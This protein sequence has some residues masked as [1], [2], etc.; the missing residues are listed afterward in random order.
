M[1]ETLIRIAGMSCQHCVTRVKK[2]LDGIAGIT[3]SNVTVGSASIKYDE[4]EV[5]KEAIASAIEKAGYKIS[6]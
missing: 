4:S 1:T 2:A 5:T 3:E 6:L